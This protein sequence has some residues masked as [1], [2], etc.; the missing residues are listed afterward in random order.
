MT[1][2]LES[3][4]RQMKSSFSIRDSSAQLPSVNDLVLNA[5]AVKIDMLGADLDCP[6]EMNKSIMAEKL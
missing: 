4:P 6:T 2:S 1:Q 3:H 5:D